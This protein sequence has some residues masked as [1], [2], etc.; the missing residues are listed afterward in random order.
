MKDTV[1]TAY[2]KKRELKFYAL[3]LLLAFLL[4]I[5]SIMIYH[6]SWQELY[7]QLGTVFELSLVIYLLLVVIRVVVVLVARA[8]GKDLCKKARQAGPQE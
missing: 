6:T 1:I 5:L 2:A 8:L 3:S 4:N 7:T